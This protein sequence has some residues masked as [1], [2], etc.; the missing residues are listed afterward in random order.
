MRLLRVKTESFPDA[1]TKMFGE[2]KRDVEANTLN[3]QLTWCADVIGT[4]MPTI[5]E[6]SAMQVALA[7]GI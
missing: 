5:M 1:I 6:A 3:S 4:A 7:A 2:S